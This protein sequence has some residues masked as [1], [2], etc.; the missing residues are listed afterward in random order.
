MGTG[1]G[2]SGAR[3][4]PFR[5]GSRV[6]LFGPGIS[7]RRR[8]VHRARG[9]RYLL[10]DVLALRARAACVREDALPSEVIS[11]PRA[12]ASPVHGARDCQVD[13]LLTRVA[14]VRGRTWPSRV[15]VGGTAALPGG[16]CCRRRRMG[17]TGRV[18]AMWDDSRRAP[19]LGALAAAQVTGRVGAMWGDSRTTR[20]LTL[21]PTPYRRRTRRR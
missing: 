15:E 18:G 11:I 21:H 16:A 5:A 17:R 10:D 12:P 20:R 2:G 6:T 8:G 19:Q 9:A 7:R 1:A 4:R 13:H 14:R 3:G